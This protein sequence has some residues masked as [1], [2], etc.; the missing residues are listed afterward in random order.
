MLTDDERREVQRIAE[1][2]G[3]RTARETLLAARE[4]VGLPRDEWQPGTVSASVAVG[5]DV[6]VRLD[7]DVNAVTVARNLTGGYVSAGARVQVLL[8]PPHGAY[9]MGMYTPRSGWQVIDHQTLT[10]T[11]ALTFDAIPSTYTHLELVLSGRA[12]FAAVSV[13]AA[14]RFN[15][16]SGANYD[17][18][19]HQALATIA[20]AAI[21]TGLTLAYMGY[22]PANT[23]AAGNAGSSRMLIPN[24][25]NTTLHKAW[26]SHGGTA[27]AGTG[28]TIR[29]NG[30]WKSTAAITRID[31]VDA[32]GG[33]TW[34]AGTGATLLG[35]AK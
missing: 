33:T 31:I 24:Y 21:A 16:D 2:V 20:S 28:Q 5:E 13:L 34:L 27:E 18:E 7:R 30:R 11:G 8:V 26:D 10:A 22:M 6:T 12:A 3:L 1:A 23:A 19:Y 32:S 15:S 4:G 14:A 29:A 9:I 25:A 17:V 35:M